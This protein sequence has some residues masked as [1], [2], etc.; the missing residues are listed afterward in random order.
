MI[1]YK[2]KEEDLIT[3]A[4]RDNNTKR[5]FLLVNPLQGKHLAVS[6]SVSVQLF[7]T[8]AHQ[9]FSRTDV[10][11][12]HTL[13]IGF[14]ETATAIGAGLSIHAPFPV[15]YIQTTRE[16]YMGKDF[17]YFNEEHSHATDQ[18]VIKDFLDQTI[19]SGCHIIFAEDE[20]T[21]GKTIENFIRVLLKTYPQHRISFGIASILNGMGNEKLEELELRGIAIDYLLPVPSYNYDEILSSYTYE[22]SLCHDSKISEFAALPSRLKE[23]KRIYSSTFAIT[24]DRRTMGKQGSRNLYPDTQLITD[25]Y[26]KNRR[27]ADTKLCY[28]TLLCDNYADTRLGVDAD[29]YQTQCELLA[30]QIIQNY[31][32]ANA[33]LPALRI[34]VLGTEECMYPGIALGQRLETDTCHQVRFHAT[35]RS[36]I[37]PSSEDSYP[38]KERYCLH[39]FYEQERITYLYNLEDYDLC[40]VVTDSKAETT[41]MREL[42]TALQNR[43]HGKFIL[44][45][46]R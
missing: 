19:H 11:Y 34:L 28:D 46:W 39:S 6:P 2:Y 23:D 27:K 37:L 25:R 31:G 33:D 30:Q 13:V 16:K 41:A 8:L 26:P 3:I 43:I 35:T 12:S 21:T 17:L 4:K 10:D 22:P 32:L 29:S 44:V 15:S 14:A 20:V 18:M 36:P 24:S 42:C 5:P 38:I 7:E 45:N 1:T 9:V 40:I